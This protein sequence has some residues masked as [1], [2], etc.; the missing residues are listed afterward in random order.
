LQQEFDVVIGGGGIIGLSM[1][2]SLI[3]IHPD[4]KIAIVEKEESVGQ[5][6]S[7]RNSGVL[8]AGFYYSPESLK[9]KFCR[10]GNIQ[11]R[12]YCSTKSIPIINTGKVVVAEDEI[13]SER[14]LALYDR[15]IE[16]G[17]DIE[18]HDARELIRFEPLA[19]THKH[20]LWSP[21]TA[22]GDP[23]LIIQSIY[24]DLK[25]KGVYFFFGQSI[26]ISND[27]K[28]HVG[29]DVLKYRHFVNSMGTQALETA[30][31]FGVG[32]DYRIIPF[33]GMY[34]TTSQKNLALR[35]L[36][37]PV[38]NP[39]NPFLGVHF[40]L[41]TDGQVKIGPTS[42]PIFGKEQYLITNIPTLK[43]VRNSISSSLLFLSGDYV[44][45]STLL[46]TEIPKLNINYLARCASKLVPSAKHVKTWKSKPAGIRAQ[47]LKIST[48]SLE[49]DFVVESTDNSTHILNAVSPGWTSSLPFTEWI[50]QNFVLPKL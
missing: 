14:L 49:Q 4:L 40:T 33:L 39:V 11:L 3:K 16:N 41:T 12:S 6:A 36:V 1:A 43:D 8:H 9:A 31:Q 37:Y 30:N 28:I 10:D 32:K 50:C 38:P 5:H 24:N 45:V 22:V 48:K 20:F 13:D 23:K 42:I 47:L 7:G 21:T 17:V 27:L 19:R 46:A 2:M 34:R 15:A 29:S 25:E 26:K 35:T 18:L 44:N